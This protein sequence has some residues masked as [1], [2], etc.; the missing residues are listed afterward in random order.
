[1]TELSKRVALKALPLL[2]VFLA[3]LLACSLRAE[4]TVVTDLRFGDNE[5]YMR[6]VMEFD[7]PLNPAP[8]FSIHGNTLQVTLTGIS[9]NLPERQSGDYH[10][11][12]IHF[13]VSS[14][15][16]ATRI[17]AV[18]A[19][20]PAD[21]RTF[22]LTEPYRFI[23]DAYR[24]RSAAAPEPP[25]EQS[26]QMALIEEAATFAELSSQDEKPINAGGSTSI[27]ELSIKPD[28]SAFPVSVIADDLHQHRFQQRL[29]AAL[30]VVT[31]IIVVL[32]LFLI[33][34]GNGRKNTPEPSWVNELPPTRDQDIENIDSA[35]GEHLKN[36]DHR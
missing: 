24:P 32:L 22:S 21:V 9:A 35:I 34:M 15:H 1:M 36:H 20:D 13:E 23:I 27:D 5:D 25:N 30:I 31:S 2:T 29:I 14:T 3:M 19:F 10:A 7:R 17:D 11:D 26:R 18:F 4:A 16:E 28:G 33:R 12:I 8:S 6:M